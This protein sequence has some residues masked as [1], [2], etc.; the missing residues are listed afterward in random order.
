MLKRYRALNHIRLITEVSVDGVS[1]V[2]E[3]KGGDMAT[4][5]TGVF[6]TSNTKLQRAI[7]RDSQYGKEFI[8]IKESRP[9]TK[10][11]VK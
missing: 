5:R 10:R 2:I 6:A 4:S 3:F 8:L 11:V 9:K 7:E 1:G